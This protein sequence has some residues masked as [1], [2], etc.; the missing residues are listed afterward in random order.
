MSTTKKGSSKPPEESGKNRKRTRTSSTSSDDSDHDKEIC[1]ELKREHLR[2]I[3][4]SKLYLFKYERSFMYDDKGPCWGQGPDL[5]QRRSWLCFLRDP[6]AY[7]NGSAA[8]ED[9]RPRLM[10]LTSDSL[11]AE[12][13]ALIKA[14][15][16]ELMSRAEAD[17][18][19]THR[20]E[21]PLKANLKQPIILEI[22][23]EFTAMYLFWS[24]TLSGIDRKPISSIVGLLRE[25]KAKIMM[26]RDADLKNFKGRSLVSLCLNHARSIQYD[27][28]GPDHH[29][30]H[31]SPDTR[32]PSPQLPHVFPPPPQIQ[33][34]VA[35]Q[36]P[37]KI[38]NKWAVSKSAP[39]VKC[40]RCQGWGHKPQV[41]KSDDPPNPNMKCF[42]CKGSGH[43]AHVCPSPK[44]QLK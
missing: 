9:L 26:L 40:S 30:D 6:A 16:V 20:Q 41:C 27:H 34:A 39:P 42:C 4:E 44:I 12:G 13:S 43:F 17:I 35:K 7:F 2:G 25:T 10:L 21:I 22:F 31:R 1:A 3:K 32:S 33:L 36:A 28:P 37:P 8:E 18:A 29:A 11:F 24:Y 19:G 5:D 38:F 15:A 23:A 14:D